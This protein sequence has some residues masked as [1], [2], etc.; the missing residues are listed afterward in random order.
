MYHVSRCLLRVQL[1]W[2]SAV[3]GSNAREPKRQVLIQV[4]IGSALARRYMKSNNWCR[5][6]RIKMTK[7]SASS[8]IGKLYGHVQHLG[9]ST[10]CFDLFYMLCLSN[11]FIAYLI[12]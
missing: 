4:A 5:I 7:H 9:V 6:L 12:V 2:R 8:T 3:P 10:H 11:V 1:Q